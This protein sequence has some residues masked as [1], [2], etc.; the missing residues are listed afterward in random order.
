MNIDILITNGYQ[1]IV[2][3]NKI[4]SG[5]NG[6]DR[7]DPNKS[8]LL[9]YYN[10][11]NKELKEQCPNPSFFVLTPNY[12]DIDLSQ[13]AGGKYYTKLL[14]RQFYEFLIVQPEYNSDILF[15]NFVN[16][17]ERHASYYCNDQYEEMKQRFLTTINN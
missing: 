7:H 10:I 3:E 2:I 6:V 15:Q 1:S 8:Q 9:K 4:T 11:L 13:Y 16:A 17:V 12:N 14:Y 5:I